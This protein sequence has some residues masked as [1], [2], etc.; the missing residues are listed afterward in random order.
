MKNII[1]HRN[2]WI[3]LGLDIFFLF[4]AYFLAY[5]IRFEGEIPPEYYHTFQRARGKL[6]SLKFWFFGYSEFIGGCGAIRAYR[7]C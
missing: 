7:I 1:K 5:F 6:F 2:F 3:I 4:L